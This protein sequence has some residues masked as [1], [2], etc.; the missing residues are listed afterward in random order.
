MGCC[1][2]A[3]VAYLTLFEVFA[4]RDEMSID[5]N[6]QSAGCSMCLIKRGMS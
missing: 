1:Q 4:Y 5:T 3:S 6:M 2:N